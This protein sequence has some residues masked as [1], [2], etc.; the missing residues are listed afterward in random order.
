MNKKKS[1]GKTGEDIAVNYLEKLGF[2]MLY[3]N[4]RAGHLETDIIC[5]DETHIL[6]VEVKTRTDTGRATR[7]GSA[8]DA[9]DVRKRQRILECAKEYIYKNKPKK[10]PRIDVIEVYLDGRGELIPERGIRH[11]KNAVTA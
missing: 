8:R 1:I 3:R 4:Y 2:K 5:E 7:F 6:F 10:K 11:I 9:V